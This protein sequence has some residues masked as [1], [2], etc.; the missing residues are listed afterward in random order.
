MNNI[1][2]VDDIYVSVTGCSFV[3]F[4]AALKSSTQNLQAKTSIVEGMT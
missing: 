4:S 1:N 2:R 3:V